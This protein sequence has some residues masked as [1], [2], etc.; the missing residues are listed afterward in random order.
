MPSSVI[1]QSC[2]HGTSIVPHSPAATGI[3]GKNVVG[4][5]HIHDSI[6]DYGR[7]LK[8]LRVAGVENPRCPQLGD[9]ASVDLVQGAVPP[10]GVISVVGRPVLAYWCCQKTLCSDVRR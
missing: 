2:T 10:S 1:E 4:R 6:H 9:I 3:E 8:P 5:S 7:R